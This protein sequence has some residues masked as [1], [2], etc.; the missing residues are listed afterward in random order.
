[1]IYK[2]RPS[3]MHFI[4]TQQIRT[5]PGVINLVAMT[6]FIKRYQC[7]NIKHV[8]LTLRSSFIY[9]W[10]TAVMVHNLTH[11]FWP[12]LVKLST[13][14]RGIINYALLER[15]VKTT[16]AFTNIS[17]IPWYVLYQNWKAYPN[18][19]LPFDWEISSFILHCGTLL[20]GLCFLLEQGQ[21]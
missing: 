15:L 16:T 20:Q 8:C 19:L 5:S 13:R 9:I 11:L 21:V 10:G 6:S 17:L 12:T 3:V 14:C 18:S 4:L 7:R 1:M 2:R